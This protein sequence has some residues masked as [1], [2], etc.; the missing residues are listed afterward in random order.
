[1]DAANRLTLIA[2]SLELG[3]LAISIQKHDAQHMFFT[4]ARSHGAA[5]P[6]VAQV[7]HGSAVQL[8][9][10]HQIW[11]S[12]RFT[13]GRLTHQGVFD[14]GVFDGRPAIPQKDLPGASQ[15]SK[16]LVFP[17]KTNSNMAKKHMVFRGDH[18]YLSWL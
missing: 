4:R 14:V 6:T 1:M 9:H 8:C 16:D 11:D 5:V 18:F 12:A 10:G 2:P 13:P 3:A 7:Q 15:T 17:N